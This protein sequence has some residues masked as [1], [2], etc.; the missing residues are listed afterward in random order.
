METPRPDERSHFLPG[1]A[2]GKPE[3]KI[4][5]VWKM[6]SVSKD[7]AERSEHRRSGDDGFITFRIRPRSIER[8]FYI[9]IIL[10]LMAS[11]VYLYTHFGLK[12]Q[13]G[14]KSDSKLEANAAPLVAPP[15]VSKV[16]NNTASANITP[17]VN[18]TIVPPTIPKINLTNTTKPKEADEGAIVASLVDFTINRVTYIKKS[19]ANN[20]TY[21]K[22]TGIDFT[23][24]NRGNRLRPQIKIYSWDGNHPDLADHQN[25]KDWRFDFGIG[26]GES[27]TMTIDTSTGTGYTISYPGDNGDFSPEKIVRLVLIDSRTNVTVKDAQKTFSIT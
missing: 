17:K 23:V 9:I 24:T 4:K 3:T 21:A 27:K 8:V 13:T 18:R 2:F 25:G 5:A 10:A 11:N 20:Y 6:N 12:C 7:D 22:V 15:P 1:H 16:V 19:G 14:A 26:K